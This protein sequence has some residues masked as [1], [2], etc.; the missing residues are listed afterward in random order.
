M[1][2][3]FLKMIYWIIGIALIWTALTLWANYAGNQNSQT[4]GEMNQQSVLIAYNPDPI[5]NLDEQIATAMAKVLSESSRVDIMTTSHVHEAQKKQYDLYV[6]CSNTYNWAPDWGIVKMIHALNLH[7]K[8]VVAITLGSGSTK[9]SHHKL[10][11]CIAK[12]K[13]KLVG[14]REFW[15]LK[16]NDDNRQEDNNVEVAVEMAI[17]FAEELAESQKLP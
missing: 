4:L 17:K 15:L 1:K 6:F 13:A 8:D 5:Y 11:A 12:K 2:P 16:P 3:K 14:D 9:A 10:K 7:R